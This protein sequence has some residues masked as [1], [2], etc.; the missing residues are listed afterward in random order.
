MKNKTLENIS[1]DCT[2]FGYTNG[3]LNILLIKRDKDPEKNSW[4]L[5]GSYINY[6]ETTVDAA[7]RV[8]NELTG[9]HDIYLSQVGVF[10][11]QERYPTHRVISIVYCALIKPDLF[12]LLAG[13]HAKEVKWSKVEN[14][15]ALPF[16]HNQ[17]VENSLRWLKKEMW[18]KPIM[19]NLL[20]EKFPLNQMQ[21]LYQFISKIPIDNRNFRKK[22][23]HQGLV[24]KL[25]EK[26]SG[27]QQRPAFLYQLKGPL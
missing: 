22:V 5:P 15:R 21:E 12:E 27:G 6:N 4:S 11:Q 23:I 24:E 1:V 2:V 26:T 13:S 7:K 19:V 10:D 18:N 16:D 20:P 14:L 8:L 3:E 25:T 9:I 17:M